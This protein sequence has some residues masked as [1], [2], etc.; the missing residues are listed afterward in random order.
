MGEVETPNQTIKPA[1]TGDFDDRLGKYLS[2]TPI[3]QNKPSSIPPY[4]QD[5]Y[6]EAIN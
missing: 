1:K 6:R 2:S 5:P 3:E 4:T